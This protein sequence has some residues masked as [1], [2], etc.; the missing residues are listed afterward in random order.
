[1]VNELTSVKIKIEGMMCSHCQNRISDAIKSHKGIKA[2]LVNLEDGFA[3]VDYIGG[4]V[5]IP[6]LC[7]SITKLGY[8]A[9]EIRE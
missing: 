8:P 3:K 5:N 7:E 9:E 6:S 1:M 4:K 2:V